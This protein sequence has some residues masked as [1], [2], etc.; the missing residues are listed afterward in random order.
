VLARYM[1]PVVPLGMIVWVSTLWRRVESWKLVVAV[2]ALSFVAAS[3]RNPP[4]GFSPEDNLA[5][6]DYIILHAHAEQYLE[7]HLPAARVLTAWPASDELS[8]PYLG[9]VARPMKVV[10]IED[11]TVEQLMSAQDL[12]QEFDA[13]FV[14]STKVEP[15][16]PL[17]ENW[18]LWREW[19]TRYFGY[20]RD[21]PPAAAAQILGGRLVFAESRGEQWV[22]IIEM[23]QIYEARSHFASR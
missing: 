14:F 17:L 16:H 2:V 15:A 7:S 20:H 18:Q 1:L 19:K 9:Y 8:R 10:R 5:Y 23:E 13:A 3:F 11:F 22:G 6:R 21:V 12:P 4:Y